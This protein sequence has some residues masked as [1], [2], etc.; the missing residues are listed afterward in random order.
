MKQSDVLGCIFMI[1]VYFL[2][3]L[4][5]AWETRVKNR[6]EILAL[7]LLFW[8]GMIFGKLNQITEAAFQIICEGWVTYKK[9]RDARDQ[10]RCEKEIREWLGIR[11]PE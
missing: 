6:R 1:A 4:V 7:A 2:P 9:R 11:K 8:P 10:A 3:G 5:L